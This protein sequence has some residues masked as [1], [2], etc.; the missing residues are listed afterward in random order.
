MK[1]DIREQWRESQ[2]SLS[3]YEKKI[4]KKNKSAFSNSFSHTVFSGTY[5][6]ELLFYQF[7]TNFLRH[8]QPIYN[9]ENNG[10]YN[11]I[12][13]CDFSNDYAH[14]GAEVQVIVEVQ[15]IITAECSSIYGKLYEDDICMGLN[16]SYN[17][18]SIH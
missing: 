17:T 2:V 14:Q 16:S 10:C 18:Q 11:E 12:M 1:I 13:L 5:Y 8:T 3:V 6:D 4:K 15:V 9:I 7:Q